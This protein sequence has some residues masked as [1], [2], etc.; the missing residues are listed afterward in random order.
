MDYAEERKR[1][2]KWVRQNLT[3]KGLPVELVGINPLER[4]PTAILFPVSELDEGIDPASED[5]E[6]D[7]LPDIGGSDH[8]A[9]EV[10][11]ATIR[12]RYIPPSSVGFSFYATGPDLSFQVQASAKIYAKP[13]GG[14][15]WKK[16][17]IGGDQSAR[18]ITGP[19]RF[20]DFLVQEP[21]RHGVQTPRAGLDVRWREHRKGE[22]TRGWI[23]TVTLFNTERLPRDIDRN[24]V[25]EQRASMSL[26]E[27]N[28]KCTFEAGTI[29]DYPR[30]EYSLLDEEEQE[31]ELRYR[32]RRIYA[33]GHGA[34]VDWKEENGKVKSIFTDFIPRT[35][36]PQ[37]T[38]DVGSGS[39]QALSIE[40]LATIDDHKPQ[41]MD[42]L[43]RF[44]DGYGDWSRQQTKGCSQ[45][46]GE[47][48]QA[49]E[50]IATRID[51]A[52]SRMR[53]GITLLDSDE[54][55]RRAFALANQA[56]LDQMM[57]SGRINQAEKEPAHY[58][59]RPFQ[60]GFLLTTI[61][62]A[63]DEQDPFRDTV[64]LIWFPTG[65]G[66]TEAYLGLI[67]FL[68]F[69]RRL[70]Y[71]TNGAGTVVLMRYT[72]RLLT[73]QQFVRAARMIFAMELLRRKSPAELGQEPFTVGLWAGGALSPNT[74][75][76]AEK[77]LG[78]MRGG[79]EEAKQALVLHQCPWC[80]TPLDPVRGYE[81]TSTRFTFKCRNE[82]CDFGGGNADA[83]PADVV[84]ESLYQN[85]PTLLFSTIDKYARLAWDERP[86]AFLG[87]GGMLPP[88]LII[89]D[90]LHL[91]SSDLGSIAGVYE[92][93]LDAVL[94]SKG[95]YPKYIASTA[96][97][98]NAKAQVK[99]MYGRELSVFPPP[100]LDADNSYFSRVVP[101]DKRPGR[102]YLGYL[103]PA[104]DRARC[105]GPLAATLAAAPESVFR[106]GYENREDLLDAWWTMVVYHGSL[107]G[108][109]NSKNAFYTHVRDFLSRLSEEQEKQQLDDTGEP[110]DER[111]V[112]RQ[113][114][115]TGQLTSL[116]SAAENAATFGRLERPKGQPECLD[117]VL[118]TNMISVGLDVARLAL[119]IIN[120]QPLTT[121]EYIQASSRV[122]RSEVPGVVF[123][124]YY[125]D[126]ARSLSHYENFRAYH[127]SFYRFVEPG[128]ITPFTH[129]ARKRALHAALVIAVRHSLST[130]AANDKAGAFDP[131]NPAIAKVIET[132][133][134]RC[135]EAS[136]EMAET[137]Q[138]QLD[139]LAA[140]WKRFAEICQ[141]NRQRLCYEERD[142]RKNSER[143]LFTHEARI[144]GLW[145]TLNS[146]R[147][148]QQS[149]LLKVL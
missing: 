97:I 66:K 26:F 122:G 114:P 113:R 87:S 143:L 5:E 18:R 48:R 59:W 31:L 73:T 93:A 112:S 119:M 76:Q 35:E 147:Q 23:I 22:H 125:R 98:R 74:L 144:R 65:G 127:E 1:L 52:V 4:F 96:T 58:C 139:G 107:R 82:Q 77:V 128:S 145:P 44:V 106:S 3:G 39:E 105:V 54:T 141:S 134:K 56:M 37:M 41:A 32:N 40:H 61:H 75:D 55:A 130:M 109:G 85:P 83:L 42:H 99:K 28:L 79:I 6:E 71:P 149:G 91:L 135:G 7:E 60:L 131:E 140:E 115:T 51:L 70:R 80:A 19:G 10:K 86:G 27:V 103:A 120:G 129:Q 69:Y 117:A 104:L 102:L 138:L 33:V 50:R 100:G 43:T 84:D 9:S 118:A 29:G 101:L 11:P 21:G 81:L 146:M 110:R 72:L 14:K 2:V 15:A 121:A 78:R 8:A 108:V 124:N 68:A 62:S 148:V 17:K 46:Q 136:G 36:V 16:A 13:G 45:L 57:Q 92:A 20:P 64:D 30:V 90:E 116:M 123:V 111:I 126:Q 38:A 63:I 95:Q 88:S 47:E 137:V 132:L 25:L 24:R 89:Q 133:S 49:A 94:R 12:R 67:A 142:D 34:A 53:G